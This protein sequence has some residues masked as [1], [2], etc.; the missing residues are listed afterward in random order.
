MRVIVTDETGLMGHRVAVALKADRQETLG[1]TRPGADNGSGHAWPKTAKARTKLLK[2][3]DCLLAV[4][5]GGEAEPEAVAKH[6]AEVIRASV[7]A[8]VRRIVLL[9]STG[10]YKP[11]VTVRGTLSERSE[12]LP[13]EALA[14]SD[15]AAHKLEDVLRDLPGDVKITVIRAPMIFCSGSPDALALIEQMLRSGSADTLPNR[16]Q[17]VDAGDLATVLVSVLRAPRS[18]GH[19]LNVAGPNA[20][21]IEDGLAELQRLYSLLTDFKPTSVNLRPEYRYAAPVIDDAIARSVLPRRA[22]TQIFVNLAQ[23]V[24]RYVENERAAGHL[25]E[26][27]LSISPAKRAVQE[28]KRPL[29][30]KVALVT[31][32]TSGIGRA[33]ALLLSRLGA[34]VVAVGRD[35]E[36]GATLVAQSKAQERHVHI[37]FLCADLTSQDDIRT[38]ADKVKK[39]HGKLDI[40]IN[41]AGAAYATRQETVDGLEKTFALN[42]MAPIMLTQLLLDP[43]KAANSARVINVNTN[44]HRMG[45]PDYDDLQSET[46]YHPMQTYATAK[47]YQAMLTRCLASRLDGS[48]VAAHLIHPGSVRT[49]LE[50]KNGLGP[51]RDTDLG[52]QAQQRMNTQRNARRRQMISSEESAA[53]VVNLAMSHEFDGMNGLYL[54]CA[55]RVTTTEGAPISDEGWALWDTC[56]RLANL[57]AP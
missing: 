56:H 32:A 10:L 53:H 40:L 48:T 43:L 21:L 11:T 16:L 50:T 35:K 6:E 25:P 17:G 20:L 47:L 2:G 57:S 12:R 1:L 7:E 24:K 28:C 18:I 54:D 38:L 49:D 4:G 13:A 29:W 9:S 23:L 52:P 33:T 55:E 3:A 34:K 42:T 26:V 46:A 44:A 27:Q 30:H 37:E 39:A 19:A 36:A 14:G 41:N 15:L 51:V 5:L 22:N 8:G 45:R 31:G